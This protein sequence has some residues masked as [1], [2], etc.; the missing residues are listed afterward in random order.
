ML[1]VYITL[2]VVSIIAGVISKKIIFTKSNLGINAI[3]ALSIGW[4]I[5]ISVIAYKVFWYLETSAYD[6][7]MKASNYSEMAMHQKNIEDFNFIFFKLHIVYAILIGM[8]FY[9]GF[10]NSSQK[11]NPSQSSSSLNLQKND[12][13]V[14]N[15][16]PNSQ[17]PVVKGIEHNF[18]LSLI[19]WIC[20]IVVVGIIIKYSY[21]TDLGLLDFILLSVVFGLM[22][23]F[24]L[25][26]PS[27]FIFK[28]FFK[29]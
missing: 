7:A 1:W 12:H 8:A 17:P 20:N 14:S 24:A 28:K 27:F 11:L 25:Y 2:I 6:I 9:Y 15:V 22:L 23:G 29:A 16:H 5:I 21:G 18:I 26:I 19:Y 10:K 3:Q 4:V 13:Q